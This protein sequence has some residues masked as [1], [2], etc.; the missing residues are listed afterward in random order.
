M[1]DSFKPHVGRSKTRWG[2]L[3]I[4]N[5]LYFRHC[6]LWIERC[7]WETYVSNQRDLI[8]FGQIASDYLGLRRKTG[9]LSGPQ[10]TITKRK[11]TP[12]FRNFWNS[13]PPKKSSNQEIFDLLASTIDV[14]RSKL[15]CE[16]DQSAEPRPSK[17]VLDTFKASCH[18][19]PNSSRSTS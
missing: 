14:L 11:G 17:K 6:I 16:A 4:V 15:T 10:I 12:K 2:M 8:T 18:R 5:A 19:P 13:N 1:Q 9:C 7:T 3:G